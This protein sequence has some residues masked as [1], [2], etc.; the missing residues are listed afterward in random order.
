MDI[1]RTRVKSFSDHHTIALAELNGLDFKAFNEDTLPHATKCADESCTNFKRV[2]IPGF[3]A[4]ATFVCLN[5]WCYQVNCDRDWQ[6]GGQV[7]ELQPSGSG[8]AAMEPAGEVEA[9]YCPDGCEYAWH[10]GPDTVGNEDGGC[11]AEDELI[12]LGFEEFTN[13]PAD[14]VCPCF[15]TVPIGTAAG[16]PGRGDAPADTAKRQVAIL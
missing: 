4:I 14:P 8:P 13:D 11:A 1:F 15:K 16:H 12:A 9:L 10:T 5:P 2:V 6:P 7:E 3:T